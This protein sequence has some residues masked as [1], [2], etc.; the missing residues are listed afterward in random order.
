MNTELRTLGR[1]AFIYGSG[2]LLARAVGF[3]LLPLYTRFLTPEDYGAIE[4]LDLTGF[5]LATV[6]SLGMEQA[7]MKYYHAY[8]EPADRHRVLS[9]AMIFATVSGLAIILAMLP[10]RGLLAR[11][12]LGS[13]R[14]ADLLYLSFVTLL[15]ATLLKLEKTMLR[16]QNLSTLF[17]KISL[18]YTAIAIV[19]NIYFVAVRGTGPAGIFYSTLINS[20]VFCA[21]LTWRIFRQAGLHY[22]HAKLR[23]MLGYGIYF[24]P[25]GLA[26]FVLN[27]ADRYFLRAS[28]EPSRRSVSTRSATRYR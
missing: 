18:V 25:A 23:D 2:F 8:S 17:T 20:T 6:M 28:T 1:H 13:P 9:T 16:A 3:L 11:Y 22:D 26:S 19:L 4:L 5:M 21:Y 14:Y 27:W 10:A 24:V 15:V 7:I 12:V